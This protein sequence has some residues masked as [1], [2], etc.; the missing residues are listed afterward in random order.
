LIGVLLD[1]W[2]GYHLYPV[3]VFLV[4][5]LYAWAILK[6]I[7][8]AIVLEFNEARLSTIGLL[9]IKHCDNV[10]NLGVFGFVGLQIF[11]SLKDT[12]VTCLGWSYSTELIQLSG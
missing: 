4:N 8:L 9:G 5:C 10:S 3:I 11:T 1:H 6:P 7:N 2:A 12:Q